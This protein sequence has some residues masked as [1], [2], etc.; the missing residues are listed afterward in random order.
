MVIDALLLCFVADDEDNDGTDGKPY[1]ASDRLRV[2]LLF[3]HRSLTISFVSAEDLT[4]T[5]VCALKTCFGPNKLS[6]FKACIFNMST[7]NFFSYIVFKVTT[8][9]IS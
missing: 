7:N 5:G 6:N 2:G 8:S 4:I 3:T 1:Y 9:V